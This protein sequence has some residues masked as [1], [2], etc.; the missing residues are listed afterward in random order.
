MNLLIVK[1][2]LEKKN[3]LTI[4]L[5]LLM[6]ESDFILGK[7]YLRYYKHVKSYKILA[8]IIITMD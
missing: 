5:K 8:V 2:N 3:D 7:M 4:I 1:D 6:F